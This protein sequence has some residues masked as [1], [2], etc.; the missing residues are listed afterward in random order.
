M[1]HTQNTVSRFLIWWQQGLLNPWPVSKATPT[2]VAVIDERICDLQGQS[3][4]D[5]ELALLLETQGVYVMAPK[6]LIMSKR[7]S[8]THAGLPLNI[9]AEDVLPFDATE[10]IFVVDDNEANIHSILKSDLLSSQALIKERGGQL[11]GVAFRDGEQLLFTKPD[12]VDSASGQ[13]VSVFLLI[14]SVLLIALVVATLGYLSHA[15][16]R[17]QRTLNTELANVLTLMNTDDLSLRQSAL[18]SINVRGADDV[19]S[20]FKSLANTLTTSTRISQL[21]LSDNELLIDASADSATQLQ[22]NLDAS[23]KYASTEFISSISRNSTDDRERFRIRA[24]L[25]DDEFS[26]AL[27]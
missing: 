19:S 25:K 2:V 18:P 27:K 20:L 13:A 22:T 7:L 5:A 8:E 14:V 6:E 26:E 21:I 23:G 1:S 10:L 17:R 12:V 4:C 15:E 11:A 16:E 9:V 24:V 3:I